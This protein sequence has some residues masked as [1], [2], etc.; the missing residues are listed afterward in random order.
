MLS[1]NKNSSHWLAQVLL[2]RRLN[3]NRSFKQPD[4][5]QQT[6]LEQST[7]VSAISQDKKWI[8]HAMGALDPREMAAFILRFKQHYPL[9]EIASIL[10]LSQDALKQLFTR[11]IVKIQA[12]YKNSR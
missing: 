5:C 4:S 1:R 3:S 6:I 8:K 12:R 7:L 2:E 9:N 11:L 10:G